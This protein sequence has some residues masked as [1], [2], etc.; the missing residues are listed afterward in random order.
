MQTPAY[1]PELAQ[2]KCVQLPTQ[3][4]EHSSAEATLK[5][6]HSRMLGSMGHLMSDVTRPYVPKVAVD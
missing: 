5:T 1:V 4:R 6:L 3:R 2:L